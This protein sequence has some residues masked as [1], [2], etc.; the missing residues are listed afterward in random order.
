MTITFS[1]YLNTVIVNITGSQEEGTVDVLS[2][3]LA[4]RLFAQS[5]MP[6]PGDVIRFVGPLPY[7]DSVKVQ[8][9][10]TPSTVNADSAVYEFAVGNAIAEYV[11][12]SVG[13]DDSVTIRRL[14]T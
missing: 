9:Q 3:P 14:A 4:G 6:S 13:Q 11:V 12:V 7:P 2:P 10:D 8:G 5:H 1:K